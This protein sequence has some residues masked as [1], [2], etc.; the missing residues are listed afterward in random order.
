M[1]SLKEK[2]DNLNSYL[3]ILAGSIIALIFRLNLYNLKIVAVLIFLWVF[4]NAI[5]KPYGFLL[6][7]IPALFSFDSIPT[8]I[9]MAESMVIALLFLYT[10]GTYFQE[11]LHNPRNFMARFWVLHVF[12]IFLT[13]ASYLQAMSNGVILSD[14]IRAI[15]PFLILYLIIPI[16]ITF[17][18]QF[19]L[20]LKWLFVSFSVLALFL[21]LYINIIFFKENFYSFYW[22]LKKDGIKIFD[23]NGDLDTSNLMGPFKARITMRIQQATSELLPVSLVWFS[24]VTV[25]CKRKEI[26]VLAGLLMLISLFAI[27]ETYTRSMLFSSVLVLIFMGVVSLFLGDKLYKKYFK[28]MFFLLLSGLVFLESFNMSELW[29]GR[30]NSLTQT[31]FVTV[32][33]NDELR[34]VTIDDTAQND[35]KHDENL[36]VRVQ[37]YKKAWNLFLLH[38]LFGAGLGIKHDMAF[39]VSSGEYLF[40]KVGYVHSWIM[41]WLMVGGVF[42]LLF[43]SFL[44]FGPLYLYLKMDSKFNLIKLVVILTIITIS[45][46]A[47]FFAVFRLISFNLILALSCGVALSLLQTKYSLTSV[48]G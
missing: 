22:L 48:K 10:V 16:S 23:I 9:G 18:S 13:I 11:F 43:Y 20:K 40:Q 17:Q 14:W 44:L 46:Y 28:V 21:T 4:F 41:Y 35:A 37:E 30:L 25:F 26:R 5:S 32:G 2:A 34:T 36:L 24:V 42:G 38:P 12:F 47:N 45:I 8:G 33:Q 1:I 29:L 39:Q 3:F 7:S 27:L 19:E 31:L 15:T 6:A